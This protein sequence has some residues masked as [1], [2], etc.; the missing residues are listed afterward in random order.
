MGGLE[1]TLVGDRKW[2]QMEDYKERRQ[3]RYHAC[4]NVQGGLRNYLGARSKMLE[5]V[6]LEQLCP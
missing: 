4:L 2:S 1:P 6:L 5:S 3:R